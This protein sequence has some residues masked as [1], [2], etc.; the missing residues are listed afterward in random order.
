M[1]KV[2]AKL[3]NIK[4]MPVLHVLGKPISVKVHSFLKQCFVHSSHG[5]IWLLLLADV[6]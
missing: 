2:K 4:V 6:S 3:Y 1:P 5:T